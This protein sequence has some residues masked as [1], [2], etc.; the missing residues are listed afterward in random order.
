MFLVTAITFIYLAY[1]FSRIKRGAMMKIILKEKP[2]NPIIIEGFPGFGL[3]GTISTEYLVNE[4]GAK[5]IGAIHAEDLPP[6]VAIHDSKVVQPIGIYYDKKNNLVIIH[7]MTNLK[8]VEWDI[9]ALVIELAKKLE[10]TDILAIEGV[11]TAAPSDKI[12]A[13]YYA[14]NEKGKKKF[15]SFKLAPL[16][17]GIILGVTSTV[18][19]Q[20]E[21]IPVSCV[22][23]ETHSSLPDSKAAAKAIEVLDKY[24]ELNIE[25]KPLMKQAEK[26][27]DKIKGLMEKGAVA[28]E[29]QKK[30]TLSYVG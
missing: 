30:K 24:L 22:F 25:Y 21:D 29:E 4:L 27:E 17:E 15:E 11:G 16:K 23:V 14:N 8:G 5:L 1:L 6:M 18:I 19:L 9:G 28:T 3:V 10:A 12:E 13:Y 7:V 2:K 20:G 26:F